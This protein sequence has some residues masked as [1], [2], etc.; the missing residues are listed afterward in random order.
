M[1]RI[2]TGAALAFLLSS[3]LAAPEEFTMGKYF[4][5]PA[6][7]T[8]FTDAGCRVGA[9]SSIPPHKGSSVNPNSAREVKKPLIA[10]PLLK[11]TE[12]L[13]TKF[14]DEYFS[15]Q[16][17]M[18]LLIL[19]DGG[20]VYENYQYGRTSDMV[21]RGF[22]MS[23]TIVGMLAGI[24]QDKGHIKSLDDTADTYYKELTGT[25]YGST[26]IRNLLRMRSGI[27]FDAIYQ[28]VPMPDRR[29]YW[30]SM[31]DAYYKGPAVLIE[32]ARYFN[33]RIHPQ[34]TKFNYSEM[35]TEIL[36]RVLIKATGMNLSEM[37]E[38]WIW[39]PIGA[40]SSA[41][42]MVYES[43]KLESSPGGFHA[44]LKD[45]GKFAL[46]LANNGR[47][48]NLQVIPENYVIEATSIKINPK[49]RNSNSLQYG[50]QTW[51]LPTNLRTF[52]MYGAF[53][54]SIIIQP[55]DNIIMVQLSVYDTE[56]GDPR[57]SRPKSEFTDKL[58]KL[59]VGK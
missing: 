38:E 54:Q 53:G 36:S 49:D 52:A 27:K 26:T 48:G 47:V 14:I 51:I 34:G 8:H 37:V 30:W 12:N 41:Y 17:A 39:K 1:K 29:R 10:A 33:E 11:Y 45:W 18:A 31:N 25:A 35:D 3:A 5:Y 20:I 40:E 32:L 55:K 19:K 22:S 23:K 57:Y 4:G 21:L 42:W 24:A 15:N 50:Y 44:T 56:V 58:F 28:N 43:D 2:L 9:W 13:D 16:K 59:F 46:M 6:C 7:S